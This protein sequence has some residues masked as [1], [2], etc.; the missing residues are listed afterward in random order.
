MRSHRSNALRGCA[1]VLAGLGAVLVQSPSADAG[2]FFHRMFGRQ[3]YQQQYYQQVPA[4]AAPATTTAPAG[5]YQSNSFE[6]GASVPAVAPAPVAV[7]QATHP[8]LRPSHEQF[9]GDRK[10]LGRY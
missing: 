8:S 9:R 2:A 10:A 1:L 7:P 4:Q 3:R 6:P 5:S